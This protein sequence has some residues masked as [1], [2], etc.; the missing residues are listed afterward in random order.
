MYIVRVFF[1][2][3]V[4]VGLISTINILDVTVNARESAVTLIKDLVASRKKHVLEKLFK[5]A[6][7]TVEEASEQQK[8][9]QS[10][11]NIDKFEKMI[12]KDAALTILGR[13]AVTIIRDKQYLQKMTELIEKYVIPDFNS[14]Y[15]FF[16]ARAC[17]IISIYDDIEYKDKNID[18]LCA[19]GCVRC[20]IQNKQGAVKVAACQALS[21]IVF[22]T[23]GL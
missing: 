7:H 22:D 16:R 4:L 20:L 6:V 12:E 17:W 14:K 1:Y 13:L 8:V 9:N 21:T 19:N 5:Q 18:K 2:V 10:D 15:F 11:T 23:N 3:Y